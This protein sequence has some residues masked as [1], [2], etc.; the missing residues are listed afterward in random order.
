VQRATRQLGWGQLQLLPAAYCSYRRSLAYRLAL[1]TCLSP[2]HAIDHAAFNRTPLVRSCLQ[3]PLHSAQEFASADEAAIA[4]DTE[5]EVQLPS[6]QRAAA[7]LPIDSAGSS[8]LQRVGIA[9]AAGSVRQAVLPNRGGDALFQGQNIQLGSAAALVNAGHVG[10]TSR[11]QRGASAMQQVHTS[12]AATPDSAPSAL[13]GA[14]ATAG[15]GNAAKGAAG[16]WAA[17]SMRVAE[18]T[19]ADARAKSST[20]G[21][22]IMQRLAAA[23]DA[24]RGA[25]FGSKGGDGARASGFAAVTSVESS[26]ER[27]LPTRSTATRG[28]PQEQTSGINES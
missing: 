12:T 5:A 27:R 11:V 23:P 20:H 6:Q 10:S 9:D 18:R 8:P 16:D 15:V 17:D 26:G 14:A 13:F 28:V 4:G 22:G 2:P 25:L 24:V 3:R 19:G 21:G 7:S 1:H